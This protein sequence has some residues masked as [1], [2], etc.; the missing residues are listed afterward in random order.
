MKQAKTKTIPSKLNKA[1]Q[2]KEKRSQKKTEPTP[3]HTQKSYKNNKQETIIPMQM[4]GRD[5]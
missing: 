1:N 2:K 4:P 3:S 5:L